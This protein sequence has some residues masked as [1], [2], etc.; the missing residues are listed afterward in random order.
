MED[1]NTWTVRFVCICGLIVASCSGDETPPTSNEVEIPTTAA[2]TDPPNEG[3]EE[4]NPCELVTPEMV[5][6]ALELGPD[7]EIEARRGSM[8]VTQKLCTYSWP[9]PAY[10]ADAHAREMMERMMKRARAGVRG[11]APEGDTLED[12]I[13]DAAS[14]LGEKFEVSYTY[15][16]ESESA[17]QARTNY[18]HAFELMNRGVSQ[19]VMEGVAEGREVTLRFPAVEVEGIGDA[20]FW[21]PRI[22]QLMVLSGQNTVSVTA[23]V[24]EDDAENLSAA[25]A[26][27][28]ARMAAL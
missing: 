20:A 18:D 5:R 26:L 6:T 28:S 3:E 17:E 24:S 22:H 19:T 2:V 11:Q 23:L 7:I 1:Q 27:A 4:P 13:V 21:S 14:S 10:D 16:P 25:K 9:N 15:M 12:G 8:R